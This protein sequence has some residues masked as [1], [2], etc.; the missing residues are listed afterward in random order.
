MWVHRCAAAVGMRTQS[1]IAQAAW[2]GALSGSSL[3]VQVC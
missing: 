1:P 2:H 3:T